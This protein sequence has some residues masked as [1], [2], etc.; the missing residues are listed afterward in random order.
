MSRIC[1][2]K[3]A[4]AHGIKGL[5]KLHVF[6]DDVT[7]ASGDLF[8]NVTG[9]KKLKITLKNATAKH[10]LAEVEGITDRTQAEKL[11]GTEL[12]TEE[13]NLPEA[14]EGAFY[15]NDLISLQAVDKSGEEIGTIIAVENF[16]ASDLLE[17]KPKESDSFYL[18]F[19]DDTVLEIT[20]DNIIIEIPEGLLE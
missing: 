5:V 6:A 14:E 9:D 1:V 3:I 17:I 12:Y 7:L 13:K 8:T 16:G 19:T 18:P 15:I 10:W 4:T 20:E 2:A 11:R